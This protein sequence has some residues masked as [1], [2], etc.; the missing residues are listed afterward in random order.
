LF[1]KHKSESFLLYLAQEGF[2]LNVWILFLNLLF[3]CER[4]G[5]IDVLPPEKELPIQ[6]AYV[7]GIQINDGYF[8]EPSQRQAL[9]KFTPDTSS[10]N[11]QEV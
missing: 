10:P 1:E 4:L 3:E 8:G 5:L 7:N 6:V 9:D 2:H 11:H